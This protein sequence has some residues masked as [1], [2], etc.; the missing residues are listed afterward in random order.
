M[1]KYYRK[2]SYNIM[3]YD[4]SSIF[5]FIN[6][7]KKTPTNWNT[8]RDY[9]LASKDGDYSFCKTRSLDEA[10][11]LCMYGYNEDF[12]KLVD[13]KITL[14]KYIKLS[15]KKNKQFNYY[16]GYAPDVKAYLEGS[17]LSMLDRQSDKRKHIDIYYNSAILGYVS[18]EEYRGFGYFKGLLPYKLCR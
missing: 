6:Y 12:N 16:V 17:P 9:R 7:L 2:N 4:F 1:Y 13:L 15:K 18:K 3:E 5:E 14:E 10:Q 8:W 11:E